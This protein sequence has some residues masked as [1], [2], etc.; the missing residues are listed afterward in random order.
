[1]RYACKRYNPSFRNTSL[2]SL[3]APKSSCQ[4]RH[5]SGCKTLGSYGMAGLRLGYCLCADPALLTRM[6]RATQAWNVSIP[7]QMA[8]IAALGVPM[9]DP[10]IAPAAS[11]STVTI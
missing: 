11:D 1:M 5:R 2:L 8:G 7:A 10:K 6:G 9:I 4:A 3:T